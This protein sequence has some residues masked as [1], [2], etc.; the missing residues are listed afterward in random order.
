MLRGKKKRKSAI[1]LIIVIKKSSYNKGKK[2][3]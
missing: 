1:K 3:A 2:E